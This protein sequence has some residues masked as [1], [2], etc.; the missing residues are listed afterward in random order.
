VDGIIDENILADYDHWRLE[1]TSTGMFE[2]RLYKDEWADSRVLYA[3][4]LADNLELAI[5]RALDWA[6]LRMKLNADP[7]YPKY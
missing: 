4:G 5:R 7:L 1:L 6:R 3:W 2:V